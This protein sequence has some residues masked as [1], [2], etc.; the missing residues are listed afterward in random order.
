MTSLEVVWLQRVK[1]LNANVD[2]YQCGVY[3]EG[4]NCVRGGFGNLQEKVQSV[5]GTIIFNWKV[6]EWMGGREGMESFLW[7]R[8]W[9]SSGLL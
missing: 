2:R 8:T 5:D 1:I 6:N 7:L 3:G 4:E 9:I